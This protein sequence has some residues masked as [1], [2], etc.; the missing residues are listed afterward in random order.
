[1]P[2]VMEGGRTTGAGLGNPS[3]PAGPTGSRIERREGGGPAGAAGASGA[4]AGAAAGGGN[5]PEAG[6]AE[7]A[8]CSAAAA[9]RSRISRRV[10]G[11]T[12]C[13]LPPC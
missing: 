9:S 10:K 11:R 5:P 12:G 3:L 4:G 8:A 6:G 1:M 13:M 7:A 2:P